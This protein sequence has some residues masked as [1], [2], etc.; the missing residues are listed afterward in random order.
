[1]ALYLGFIAI[2][3]IYINYMWTIYRIGEIKTCE[4][5]NNMTFAECEEAF[6]S[7]NDFSSKKYD[8]CN[9][10]PNDKYSCV[11]TD[12]K[13]EDIAR[14]LESKQ[15]STSDIVQ[16]IMVG[17][18]LFS[19]LFYLSETLTFSL[20]PI[21]MF[22]FLFVPSIAETQIQQESIEPSDF[23]DKITNKQ[24][25]ISN[26]FPR[27]KSCTKKTTICV[28]FVLIF[29]GIFHSSGFL[30]KYFPEGTLFH[31]K[32]NCHNQFYDSHPDPQFLKCEG[33]NL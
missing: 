1:M 15:A 33:T 19:V 30:Y 12:N 5:K 28:I 16:Y 8:Q 9:C 24:K 7:R 6:I 17:N 18:V 20:P 4:T 10:N 29:F 22:D 2:N 27:T 14:M 31:W 26:L 21:S 13:Q 11:N 32:L 3:Q 23:N 25:E